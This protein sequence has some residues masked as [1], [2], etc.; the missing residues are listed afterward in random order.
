MLSAIKG[1]GVYRRKMSSNELLADE[2]QEVIENL[3]NAPWWLP[4]RWVLWKECER[5]RKGK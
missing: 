1:R 4:L 3:I 5:I 2:Y